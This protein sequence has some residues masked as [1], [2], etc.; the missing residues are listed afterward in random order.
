MLQIN[1]L[2]IKRSRN[3]HGTNREGRVDKNMIYLFLVRRK[4]IGSVDD[5]RSRRGLRGGIV[6]AFGSNM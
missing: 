3:T 1:T 6:K 4:V 2:N 5:V